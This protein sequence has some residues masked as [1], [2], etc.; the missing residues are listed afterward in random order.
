MC[1]HM[2]KAFCKVQDCLQHKLHFIHFVPHTHMV[3]SCKVHHY[4]RDGKDAR[5]L[6]SIGHVTVSQ[7]DHN[8]AIQLN[9]HLVSLHPGPAELYHK[10]IV[11]EVLVIYKLLLL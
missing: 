7:S 10:L 5:L 2:C 11:M 4:N 6:I 1:V 8:Y 3:L 9:L